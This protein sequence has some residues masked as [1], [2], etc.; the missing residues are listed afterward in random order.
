[1]GTPPQHAGPETDQELQ[2]AKY[3]LVRLD[4]HL[5]PLKTPYE[6]PYKVL[7][8]ST[9]TFTIFNGRTEDKVSMDRLKPPLQPVGRR[10]QGAHAS[11]TRKAARKDN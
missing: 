5:M 8:K 3:V 6:G 10:T 9:Y 2:E 7:E 11:P 4:Y 1:M